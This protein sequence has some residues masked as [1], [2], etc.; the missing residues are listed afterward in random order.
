MAVVEGMCNSRPNEVD[1][2]QQMESLLSSWNMKRICIPGDGYCLFASIAFSLVHR[3]ER[4]DRAT[5]ECLHKLGTPDT[6]SRN[7]KPHTKDASHSDGKGMDCKSRT[8][9]RMHY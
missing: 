4:G 6:H 1:N 2:G 8:L 7:V 9:S 3:V 5:I